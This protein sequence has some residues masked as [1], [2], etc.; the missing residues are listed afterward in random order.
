MS[1]E[2][3]DA[4]KSGGGV[5]GV[6]AEL[7]HDSLEGALIVLEQDRE[8]S[9]LLLQALVLEHERDVEPLELRVELLCDPKATASALRLPF[10]LPRRMQRTLR[11][12]RVEPAQGEAR[13]GVD[14]LRLHRHATQPASGQLSPISFLPQECN[15]ANLE[16]LCPPMQVLRHLA[17]VRQLRAELRQERPEPVELGEILHPVYYGH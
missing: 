15:R 11:D 6:G 3:R 2:R 14:H 10:S 1:A 8:L 5:Y 7:G 16:L 9:V 4:G 12:V 17:V 13:L